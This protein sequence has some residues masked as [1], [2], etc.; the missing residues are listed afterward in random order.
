VTG[1]LRPA[2]HRASAGTGTFRRAEHTHAP[3]RPGEP[4]AIVGRKLRKRER[5]TLRLPMGSLTRP[6]VHQG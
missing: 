5:D 6:A 2:S 3:Q 1:Y 4:A